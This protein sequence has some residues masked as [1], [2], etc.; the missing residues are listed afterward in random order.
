MFIT[1][2]SNIVVHNSKNIIKFV[3]RFITHTVYFGNN[4]LAVPEQV[5][6]IGTVITEMFA[7]TV[8]VLHTAHRI[9]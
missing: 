9:N 8:C 4:I 2:Y 3:R 6:E 7:A 5:L 1:C